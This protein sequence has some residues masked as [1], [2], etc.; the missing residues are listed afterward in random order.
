MD[1]QPLRRRRTL[2]NPQGFH[3]RPSAAFAELA[4]RFQCA[5]RVSRPGREVNGK[6]VLDLMLLN[7][8]QGT[9]ITVEADGPDAAAALEALVG[10]LD[11]LAQ[12]EFEEKD[13][14]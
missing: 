13:E 10:L 8:P 6:S 4:S 11:R 2:T 9:E 14:G 12:G 7:A 3:M 5:V 1:C